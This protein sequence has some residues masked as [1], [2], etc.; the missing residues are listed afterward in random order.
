M[1]NAALGMLAM[2]P[3]VFGIAGYTMV[4]R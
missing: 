2:V 1:L 4:T 3:A